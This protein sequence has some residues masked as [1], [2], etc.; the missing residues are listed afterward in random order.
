MNKEDRKILN[1]ARVSGSWSYIGVLIPIVGWILGTISLSGLKSIDYPKN[2]KQKSNYETIK[3]IAIGGIIVSTISA[4]TYGLIVYN[5]LNSNSKKELLEASTSEKSC[6]EQ[7]IAYNNNVII[8][9][10]K[11][12]KP[13][14]RPVPSFDENITN[15]DGC[16]RNI[17][18]A[19]LTAKTNYNRALNATNERCID[20]AEQNYNKSLRMNANSS[21]LDSSGQTIY[22]LSQSNISRIQQQYQS[23]K[24]SCVA[25]FKQI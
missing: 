23:E 5:N 7:I 3:R 11:Y 17:N 10:S 22:N 4:T 9:N 21:H 18:S 19:I 8:L 12:T 16:K 15:I 1:S 6:E 25:E 20:Q 13:K 24:D 14:T 2:K